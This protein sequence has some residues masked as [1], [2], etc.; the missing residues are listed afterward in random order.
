[1]T[2]QL[3]RRATPAGERR[4]ALRDRAAHVNRSLGAGLGRLAR[5]LRWEPEDVGAALIYLGFALL[6]TFRLWGLAATAENPRDHAQFQFFF[7]HAA[8]AL[9]QGHNPLFTTHMGA[10]LGVNLM[11][12]TAFMGVAVPLIPVTLLLGS[13]VSYG[14]ALTAGLAGTAIAWYV[15]LRRHITPHR[16][17]AFVGGALCG[18]APGIVGHALGHPNFVA[19]FLLPFIVSGVVRLR[20]APRPARSGLVLGLLIAYQVFINEELLFLTALACFVMVVVYLL[21]RPRQALGEAPRFLAGLAVAAA[22]TLALTAYP[23]WFQ[24]AG[25]QHATGPIYWAANWYN[26]VAGLAGYPRNGISGWLGV[27]S[28][29]NNAVD[30]TNGFLGLPLLVLAVVTAVALW[31]L[32]AVRIAAA[33]TVVGLLL[34]LGDS[35]HVQGDETIPGLYHL[36]R[37]LP[38]FDSVIVS[39]FGLIATP[40]V[41]VLLACAADK[42]LVPGP[43]RGNERPPERYPGR[44]QVVVW[45]ALAA[46]VLPIAPMP[47][48]VAPPMPVPGFFAGGAWRAH[49]DDGTVVPVPPGTASESTVRWILATDLQ[50]RFVDGYFLGPMSPD[51]DAM[52]YG[53]PDRPTR[54]LLQSVADTGAIPEISDL[55]RATA[56]DDLRFWQADALVLAPQQFYSEQLR[57]T[58]DQLV[59]RP[60]GFVDGVWVW[61]VRDLV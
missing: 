3:G 7:E 52:R 10:P 60:G 20:T 6:L 61:D 27:G 53:P 56:L 50:V 39:R 30:E 14:L 17:A 5:R 47:V 18:F 34:S 46:L 57:Q 33:V 12:N 21:S 31:K 22:V 26:D 28:Y 42:L 48:K 55:D 43:T 49:V 35:I 19:Q 54:L 11:S 8:W 29:Y 23:L 25:P 13:N 58:V 15:V 41:A 59:G 45:G 37:N 38:L 24:F 1:V 51:D 9:T 32:L 44:R 16:G 36:L 40:A 4:R 2:T